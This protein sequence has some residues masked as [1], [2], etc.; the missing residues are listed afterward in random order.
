MFVF[1]PG[2]FIEFSDGLLQ[3]YKGSSGPRGVRMF[4]VVVQNLVVNRL[5]G[6]FA[7]F[8]EQFQNLFYFVYVFFIHENTGLKILYVILLSELSSLLSSRVSNRA[9]AAFLLPVDIIL[10]PVKNAVI[11]RILKKGVSYADPVNAFRCYHFSFFYIL[12]IP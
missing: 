2:G 1:H 8:I 9:A 5:S 10:S 12:V 11:F 3:F 6:P 7:Y 4:L